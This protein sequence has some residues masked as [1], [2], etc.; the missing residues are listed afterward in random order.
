MGTE[1]LLRDPGS[2]TRRGVGIRGTGLKFPPDRGQS[3]R[4]SLG[5]VDVRGQTLIMESRSPY[6]VPMAVLDR[7][8][9]PTDQQG[10]EQSVHVVQEYLAAEDLDRTR[11]LSTSSAGRLHLR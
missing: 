4:T 7:I 5:R 6:A 2:F 8:K 3:V 10:T 11:L 9:V 1:D